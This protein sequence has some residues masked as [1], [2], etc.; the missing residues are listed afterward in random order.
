MGGQGVRWGGRWAVGTASGTRSSTAM[1]DRTERTAC[2][3]FVHYLHGCA[4]A[5]QQH[6]QG[7]AGGSGR[8]PIAVHVD[9]KRAEYLTRSQ[10]GCRQLL[11][12]AGHQGAA[13]VAHVVP[14]EE[15]GV[16]RCRSERANLNLGGGSTQ[17]CIGMGH[18]V[19]G[20]H[21]ASA[22]A[23]ATAAAAALEVAIFST[24]GAG[25]MCTQG[26]QGLSLAGAVGGVGCP[27]RRHGR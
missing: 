24:P 11:D 21:A 3:H 23:A 27:H 5:E 9:R 16:G 22:A 14:A 25:K 26:W 6:G 7:A 13:Q 17:P 1:A 18:A 15:E 20:S 12:V 19:W 8:H 10:V 4:A 2:R